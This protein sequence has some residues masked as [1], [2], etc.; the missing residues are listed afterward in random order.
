M[1]SEVRH[2]CLLIACAAV[3][4]HAALLTRSTVD[5]G[6]ENCRCPFLGVAVQLLLIEAR[7]VLLRSR[8]LECSVV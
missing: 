6:L 4:E 7:P 8:L 5:H 2:T 1:Y 3:K